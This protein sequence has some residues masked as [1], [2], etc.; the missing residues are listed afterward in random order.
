MGAALVGGAALAAFAFG[1]LPGEMR[2]FE[3]YWTAAARALSA[4]PIYRVEDGHYQFKYLPA[5]AVLTAPIAL[6]PLHLAKAAWFVISVALLAGLIALS[7]ALLPDRR[8]PSWI[9]ILIVI[10]AMGKFYG[11]EIGLGQVNLLFAV[12][13]AAGIL[14]TRDRRTIAAAIFLVAATAVKPYAVLLLPWLLVRH[15]RRALLPVAATMAGVLLVPALLY[16]WSGATALHGDWWTTVTT[17]TAPN[18]TNADNVSL[19]G[20]FAKWLGSGGVTAI[21]TL[22]AALCLLSACAFVVWK[23]RDVPRSEALEGALLLTAIPLLS[24]QGWDYVF[25]VATPAIALFANYERSLPGALRAT[26]WLAVLTMGLSLFDIMGRAHYAEFM[27]WSV[28]TVCVAVLVA[29]LVT[30]RARKAA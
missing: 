3:V 13:V 16:G 1:V 19:A 25:L 14:M 27:A 30:L 18:L 21:A 4:E 9:L 23:G 29:A 12:L 17:S 11:H 2:D 7:L 8:R 6:V 20:F 5:F 26:A 15:G 10:V 28:I 22:V 24:P